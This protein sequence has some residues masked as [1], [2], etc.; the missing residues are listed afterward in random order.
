MCDDYA[1]NKIPVSMLRLDGYTF[2]HPTIF[3]YCYWSRGFGSLFPTG[4]EH[5][6]NGIGATNRQEPALINYSLPA[7][8]R[9]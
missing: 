3:G 1:G 4:G 2:Q 7:V 8:T 6:N 9:G 5:D